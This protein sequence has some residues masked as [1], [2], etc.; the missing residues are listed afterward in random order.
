MWTGSSVV[1]I[2]AVVR[3]VDQCGQLRGRNGNS[4]QCVYDDLLKISA[5]HWLEVQVYAGQNQTG[6]AIAGG[7]S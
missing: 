4:T 2:G 6:L 7:R 1:R 3:F 5:Y